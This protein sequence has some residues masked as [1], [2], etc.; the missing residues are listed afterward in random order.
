M[1][2]KFEI[3]SIDWENIF[4]E[5]KIRSDADNAVFYLTR[6]GNA[7]ANAVNN[8]DSAAAADAGAPEIKPD[9]RENGIWFFRLNICQMDGRGFL[10]NGDWQ[11]LAKSEDKTY[12]V[13]ILPKAAESFAALSRVFR[14]A[15]DKAYIITFSFTDNVQEASLHTGTADP[16][17]S[18]ASK[19]DPARGNP[20]NPASTND[21]IFILNST[22]MGTDPGWRQ[23]AR[24]LKGF[25]VRAVQSVYRKY[26][27]NKKPGKNIL[28]LSQTK[29]RIDGNLKAIDDRIRSRGLNREYTISYYFHND[30]GN[31]L[32]KRRMLSLAR[33]IARQDIIF[34]DNYVPIFTLLDPPERCRL[35]QVWHAGVGF[36]AVGYCRFGKA[37]SPHPAESCHRKYTFAAA[38]TRS[39]IDVYREVFGI[40]KDAFITAGMPRLDGFTDKTHIENVRNALFREHPELR[41]GKIILFA[42]TYRGSGQKDAYYDYDRLDF[43]RIAEL[44]RK[45][46]CIFI[47]KMH[48]F[49]REAAPV[50]DICRDVIFDFSGFPDINDLYY[51]TDL[52]ISD[53]SSAY[54]EY[55]LLGRPVLFYTYDRLHYQ[56]ERG[57]HRDVKETAPGKV[58]DTFDEMITAIENNDFEIEKTDAFRKN[59][60]GEMKNDSANAVIDAVLKK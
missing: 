26:A 14:Y 28:F 55:A 23:K 20:P 41:T 36:K 47:I 6:T 50:P 34:V 27:N 59:Y 48:P 54:Y 8:A 19:T 11:I 16:C 58:C 21:L 15:K 46:N 13:L 42:P 43:V 29:D 53:Y 38:P 3:F 45:R 32:S 1:S 2:M 7:A 56:L 24:G 9:S 10:E 40:E 60:L 17:N 33:L 39:A 52:L 12:P 5:I 18:S 35:I 25:V 57:V 4:L 49:V 30:V 51:I 44:C 37:G 31:G 22:F